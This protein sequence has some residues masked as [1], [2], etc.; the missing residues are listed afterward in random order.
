M[1]QSRQD[2]YPGLGRAPQTRIELLG[3]VGSE[4]KRSTTS[5]VASFV[6]P[7]SSM[8]PEIIAMRQKIQSDGLKSGTIVQCHNDKSTDKWYMKIIDGTVCNSD[9]ADPCLKLAQWF[10][11]NST[12]R[13]EA[14]Q[15]LKPCYIRT[16]I[17]IHSTPT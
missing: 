14:R 1:Q 12:S 5:Q 17:G 6:L 8:N 13:I 9:A 4:R 10:A 2:E 7:Q 16:I 15:P 3:S 11:S